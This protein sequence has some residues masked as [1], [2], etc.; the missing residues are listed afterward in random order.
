MKA[1]AKKRERLRV[2]AHHNMMAVLERERG[3]EYQTLYRQGDRYIL[4]V[5]NARLW[6]AEPK[7]VREV[8]ERKAKALVWDWVSNSRGGYDEMLRPDRPV[9]KVVDGGRRCGSGG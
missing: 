2:I 8:T 6:D 9:L 4:A 3:D 7:S 1:V 5:Y